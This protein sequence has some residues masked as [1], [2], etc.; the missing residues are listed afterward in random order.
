[1][2]K[3]I[4]FLSYAW[5]INFVV[6]QTG[7]QLSTS[8]TPANEFVVNIGHVF[9]LQYRCMY[10]MTYQLDIPSGSNDLHVQRKYT[11][12]DAWSLIPEKTSEDYFNAIEAVRFDYAN[13]RAYVSA[14]FSPA[15]DSLFLQIIDGSSNPITP[16]YSGI[17]K[18]YD[19]RV[20]AV[21]V[22]ADDYSSDNIVYN[23]ID[24]YPPLLDIFRSYKLYVTVGIVTNYVSSYGWTIMQQ[25]LDSGY[26][27][28]ASHSRTHS[29]I[30]YDHPYD[31]V[32]GSHNDIVS[33]LRLPEL[34]RSGSQGYVYTWIPPFGEHDS[35]VVD[36]LIG[37]AGYLAPRIYEGEDTTSPR[38]YI[39]G[40]TTFAN[41]NVERNHFMP[42]FPS[43]EIGAPS[44]GGGDTSLA[45]LNG[46]FDAVITSGGIYHFMWHPQTIFADRDSFYLRSHL[47]YVSQ[48]KNIWY[49]NLG[50]LY[51]YHLLQNGENIITGTGTS[52]T[53]VSTG[54]ATTTTINTLAA[55]G[56]N[57]FVGTDAGVFHT[58]DNGLTW[59]EVDNGLTNKNVNALVAIG[60]NLFAGTEGN[61]AFLSTDNGADWTAVN[62]DPMTWT[63]VYL[64]PQMVRISLQ[65]PGGLR[66]MACFFPPTMVQT[67]L[68]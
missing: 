33:K 28:A 4:F 44:W 10:P 41:W 6:A 49:V 51:L 53:E 20:A 52:W 22:S 63:H 19:N 2:K 34:F 17:S 1:M 12:S 23:S 66:S 50:H 36:S 47:E 15:S 16:V 11:S 68:Q 54:F 27:E 62:S 46:F 24:L 31:E 56:S 64:L 61:G 9:H 32:V 58:T 65:V 13:S 39:Y 8:V 30:P 5:F 67:G 43:L 37:V 60:S 7:P 21:T 57:I 25:Q 35:T 14:A 38:V 45:S 48:R 40:N 42:F 59:P 3:I 55:I 26:V 29:H 18:Y